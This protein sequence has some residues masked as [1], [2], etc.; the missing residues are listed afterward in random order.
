LKELADA[1]GS[2][3]NLATTVTNHIA[4]AKSEAEAYTDSSIATEHK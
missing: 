2:D 1:L 4:T 3:A